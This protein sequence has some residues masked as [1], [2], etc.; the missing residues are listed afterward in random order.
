MARRTKEEAEETRHRLLDAAELVFCER[1][2]SG[3]SLADVARAAGLSRGAIYWHFKD[4]LDLFEAM[5][6]RV[7]LPMEQIVLGDCGRHDG[8]N[9]VAKILGY[10][11]LI[12]EAFVND[13]RTR[14]VFEVAMFKV[15]HVG[16]LAAVQQRWIASADRFIALLEQKLTQAFAHEHHNLLPLMP[17]AVSPHL[18]A[19]GLHAMFDGL[20]TAWMLRKGG[21]DLQVQGMALLRQYLKSM[22]LSCENALE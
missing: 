4:K 18:A 3:A 13:E 1:G 7:I 9:P 10:F 11:A 20:L 2:V 16:E 5:M 22:G 6:Q 17:P 19:K 21:F 14:R 15:E 12:F 8:C